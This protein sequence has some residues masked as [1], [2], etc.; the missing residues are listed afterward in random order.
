MKGIKKQTPLWKTSFLRCI[1]LL[2]L[3][4]WFV[5][6]ECLKS[7]P[8]LWFVRFSFDT[9]RCRCLIMQSVLSELHCPNQR[10]GTFFWPLK[11]MDHPIV[12][13]NFLHA[14]WSLL[15]FNC[16][17]YIKTNFKSKII[18]V[19]K[20]LKHLLTFWRNSFKFFPLELRLLSERLFL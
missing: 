6:S 16:E 13:Q 8:C 11:C 9:E 20:C 7:T 12:S 15:D 2:F 18:F 3:P 17:R 10:Q 1:T 14:Q 4:G 19:L 5:Y